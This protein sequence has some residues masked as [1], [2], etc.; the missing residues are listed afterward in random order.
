MIYRR[1]LFVVITICIAACGGP[2]DNNT[3]TEDEAVADLLGKKKDG[4][5]F[6]LRDFPDPCNL[7]SE[8]KAR[9]VLGGEVKLWPPRGI[10]CTYAGTVN[11]NA[12]KGVS[13]TM[14]FLADTMIDSIEMP[15]EELEERIRSLFW[16]EAALYTASSD[17]GVASF[18]FGDDK[19]TALVVLTGI[20][21]TAVISDRIVSEAVLSY[22]LLDPGQSHEARFGQ[23]EELATE[24]LSQLT[25]LARTSHGGQK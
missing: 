9:D 19:K 10:S 21:G 11:E 5:G 25:V 1:M 15:G 6:F 7:L 13:V 2:N 4:E 18:T 16:Q 20:G 22:T 14:Q 8:E 23:L 24:Q 17:L 3:K 12:G